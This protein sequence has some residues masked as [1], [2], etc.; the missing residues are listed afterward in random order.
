MRRKMLWAVAAL[1]LLAGCSQRHVSI[2]AKISDKQKGGITF[3]AYTTPLPANSPD[4][5]LMVASPV[6]DLE[7]RIVLQ[8]PDSVSVY[9]I[10]MND[11][12]ARRVV[13]PEKLQRIGR[14]IL[15]EA[16]PKYPGEPFELG[17]FA[18]IITP[19]PK[20]RTLRETSAVSN[21]RWHD[22]DEGHQEMIREALTKMREDAASYGAQA[23]ID[24]AISQ[25]D[26]TS[27]MAGSGLLITAKAVVFHD[28]VAPPAGLD[29]R[30]PLE[31]IPLL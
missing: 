11:G 20:L 4:E 30:S 9:P 12:D 14:G 28:G 18:H 24:I 13:H 2:E 15:V 6:D 25:R 5:L 17:Y 22:V 29:H 10:Y 31:E 26:V 16:A 3:Y 8:I 1:V 7:G 27:R 21:I 23:V 19:Y